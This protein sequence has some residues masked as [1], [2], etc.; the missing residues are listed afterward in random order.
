MTAVTL[1]R[2]QTNC[3][4]NWWENRVYSPS[5]IL[6][7]PAG[8]NDRVTH[9]RNTSS[10]CRH[11]WDVARRARASL[12][13]PL[14]ERRSNKPSCQLD[15]VW[16]CTLHQENHEDHKMS[17]RHL[18][19]KAT[20]QA[21]PWRNSC[22][23]GWMSKPT[24]VE[25]SVDN[26]GFDRHTYGTGFITLP[27]Q[28]NDEFNKGNTGKSTFHSPAGSVETD[29]MSE[30]STNIYYWGDNFAATGKGMTYSEI[31]G[32]S[33]WRGVNVNSFW[34][35]S[36]TPSTKPVDYEHQ[37]FL[38]VNFKVP[39]FDVMS[40]IQLG[41]A[42]QD[43]GITKVF[44]ASADFSPTSEGRLFVWYLH[45]ARSW[46]TRKVSPGGLHPYILRCSHAAG[47]DGWLC[48]RPTFLRGPR[49]RRSTLLSVS[50]TSLAVTR[51]A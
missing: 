6:P 46:L 33:C 27:R 25:S 10:E 28:V 34:T 24:T 2:K 37:K 20:C 29:F 39:K 47:W 31:C 35:T 36:L 1:T 30:S 41:E 49:P 38:I 22:K 11:D 4:D 14:H 40:E 13:S 23:S 45:A 43:L 17:I 19:S 7:K 18:L 32:S 50:S 16:Q 44:T 12:A 8:G 3:S 26:A 21:L 9:G 51:Q 5:F 42:M 15:L 48:L